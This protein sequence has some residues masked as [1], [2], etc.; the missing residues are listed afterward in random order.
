M[1]HVGNFPPEAL[2]ESFDDLLIERAIALIRLGFQPLT[3]L[4]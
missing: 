1:Y 2:L 4:P 3:Q